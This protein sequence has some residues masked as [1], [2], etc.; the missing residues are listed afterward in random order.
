MG[1]Y[2][3]AISLYKRVVFLRKEHCSPTHWSVAVALAALGDAQRKKGELERAVRTLEQAQL[4]IVKSIGTRNTEYVDIKHSLARCLIKQGHVVQATHMLQQCVD[5]ATALVTAQHPRVAELHI[6]LG[7][8]KEALDELDAAKA[9]FNKA[10]GILRALRATL[11]LADALHA[12]AA[13]QLRRA[14]ASS[15]RL[16]AKEGLLI[17]QKVFGK[18]TM[19]AKAKAFEVLLSE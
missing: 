4:L 5:D 13:F 19:H 12:F 1:H 3:K 10:I 6:T 7:E 15:A 2:E 16:A 18:G 8:A 9:H 17:V 14:A 11:D